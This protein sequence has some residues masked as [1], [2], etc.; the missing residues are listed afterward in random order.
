LIALPWHI[1][2]LDSFGRSAIEA[3][4]PSIVGIICFVIVVVAV[5]VR[6]CISRT[7]PDFHQLGRGLFALAILY[8][9]GITALAF[10]LT[11]PPAVEKIPRETLVFMGLAIA[12]FTL[13][14][15]VKEFWASFFED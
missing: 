12:I 9:G 11:F 6:L 8:S 5:I 10:V 13:R 4:D 1:G 2:N 14:I 7:W 3:T 15:G